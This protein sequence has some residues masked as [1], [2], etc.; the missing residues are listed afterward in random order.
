MGLRGLFICSLVAAAM[1]TLAPQ[2]NAATAFFTRDIWQAYVRPRS[3][4]RELI[5][6]SY[7]FGAAMVVAAFFMAYKTAKINEIW[8]WIIMALAAGMAV[9]R[10]LRL[11]W[12]RFNGAGVFWSC[13]T[14]LVASVAQ[15]WY[16]TVH[17]EAEAFWT[18]A[19]KF[20]VITGIAVVGAIIG[21]YTAPPT[22]HA[23]LM[24][25]YRT[26]RPFGF[27]ARFKETLP[28]AV[29]LEMTR[30]TARDVAAVPFALLWQ[31]TLFLLPMQVLLATWRDFAVTLVLFGIGLGGLLL[32]WFRHLPSKE[33]GNYPSSILMGAE[34]AT[35]GP[36]MPAATPEV[37]AKV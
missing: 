31:I 16:V 29:Q 11:Y 4:N 25:F 3:R 23:V 32:I 1:S 19:M 21:T 22:D 5:A 10:L 17:P 20:V 9:P 30:E 7:V 13:M 14:G 18:P 24:R 12:W 33:Q 2:V 36:A 26:T 34:Q 8:D 15:R 6:V 27:W 35:A 37:A 28:P